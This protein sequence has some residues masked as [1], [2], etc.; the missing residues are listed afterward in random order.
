MQITVHLHTILQKQRDHSLV[1]QLQL[2]LPSGTTLAELL[3]DLK[4]ELSADALLM[5]VNGR[6]AGPER[7][8]EDGDQV[9][10]M[11]AISGGSG[12]A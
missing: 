10:L 8:L 1:D 9:N 6:M 2:D 12:S 5:A 11:P 7:V 4:I 3:D